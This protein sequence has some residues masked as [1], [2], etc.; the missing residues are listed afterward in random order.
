MWSCT[1]APWATR[2]FKE[3]VQGPQG[4]KRFSRFHLGALFFARQRRIPDRKVSVIGEPPVG[5]RTFPYP[6]APVSWRRP[7]YKGDKMIREQDAYD[8]PKNLRYWIPLTEIRS[9][10]NGLLYHS[11]ATNNSNQGV[12][13]VP[14]LSYSCRSRSTTEKRWAARQLST[15]MRMPRAPNRGSTTAMGQMVKR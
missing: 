8:F 9:T 14:E 11:A 5:N 1:P 4:G 13:T 7:K 15:G 2:N 3:K 12:I 10:M 6:D